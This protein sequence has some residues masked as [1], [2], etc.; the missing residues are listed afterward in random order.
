M[1]A[2]KE[3]YLVIANLFPSEN[4]F[5]GSYIYDQ[6]K[7]I[8]RNSNL[9]VIVLKPIP[10]FNK[11]N[12]YEFDGVKVYSFV[13][14]NPPSNLWPN[15]ITDTLSI[16][17]MLKK[18]Q[19]IGININDIV[20]AHSH[21]C[22]NGVFANA[23]KEVNPK[24]I[25]IVQHHGFDVMSITDGR[26]ANFDF[27]KKHCIN[28]GVNICNQ[29]DINI[30]VSKKTLS[31]VESIPGI[32]LRSKYVLYN[33]VDT[34]TFHPDV[35]RKPTNNFFTIGCVANF[36]ELKDQMTLLKAQNELLKQGVVVRSCFVGTGYTR[37]ECEDYVKNNGLEKYVEFIDSLPHS[38]LS[39]FYRN[40]DLFVLPSY[41]E[42]FGCVYTEAYCCGV[43]FVGVN[44]QGIAEILP[45]EEYDKWL[46]NKGD[47]EHLAN[48]IKRVIKNPSHSQ[49]LLI[50]PDID[51]IIKDYLKHL[52]LN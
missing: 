48:I 21:I 31:Y 4:S 13:D 8:E 17:S 41:W 11:S 23:L 28:Y 44:D 10:F 1:R 45:E 14:Y 12:D 16:N 46:I 24:I 39:E 27:H 35:S 26:L 49:K 22:R 38:K 6:V 15:K 25:S 47:F 30:G 50:N 36:W 43:P 3:Y 5:R 51:A 19:N 52:N 29:I 20:V 34:K 7:A 18:I 32:N 33:G 37:G 42:A 9:E 2:T 40:I